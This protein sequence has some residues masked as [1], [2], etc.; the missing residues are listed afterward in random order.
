MAANNDQTGGEMQKSKSKQG[1]ATGEVEGARSK[2][3][4]SFNSV[5]RLPGEGRKAASVTE[6]SD[7]DYRSFCWPCY[8]LEET[9]DGR[10]GE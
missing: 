8:A 3:C 5:G 2:L 6:I 1:D 7:K 10:P 9:G 4:V